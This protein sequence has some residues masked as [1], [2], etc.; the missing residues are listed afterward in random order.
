MDSKLFKYANVLQLDWNS[1]ITEIENHLEN[2][3]FN[4]EKIEYLIDLKYRYYETI[5]ISPN[6]LITSGMIVKDLGEGEWGFDR[7]IT[8]KINLINSSKENSLMPYYTDE[9]KG[10]FW[11]LHKNY[12]SEDNARFGYIFNE[13]ENRKIEEIKNSDYQRF[14]RELT[15]NQKLRFEADKCTDYTKLKKVELLAKKYFDTNKS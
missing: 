12:L 4:F 6:Y 14:I 1:K 9:A 3:K 10:L 7:W 5:A 11:Y 13:I 15:G 8:A 2:L